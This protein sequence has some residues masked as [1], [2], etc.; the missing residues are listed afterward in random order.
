MDVLKSK[1]A[2]LSA[3][4]V[5]A[6]LFS[7][8]LGIDLSAEQIAI[9]IGGVFVYVTGDSIRQSD[10]GFSSKRFWATVANFAVVIGNTYFKAGLSEADIIAIFAA[11]QAFIIGDTIREISGTK[12]GGCNGHSCKSSPAESPSA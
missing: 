6:V 2:V 5:V 4:V 11:I 12:K 9:L 3:V 10:H 1:R 8:K 7:Q